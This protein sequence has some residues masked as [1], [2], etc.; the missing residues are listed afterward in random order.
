MKRLLWTVLGCIGLVA[1][2]VAEEDYAQYVNPFIGCAYNGHTFPGP[3]YPSGLVQPSPDSGKCD[4]QHCSGYVYG[5]KHIYGFTQ[6]HLSGTG[7]PDL[8]DVRLLPFTG[9]DPEALGV[10][11]KA[12]EAA[13]PGYY[14]ATLSNFGVQAE[15][16]CSRRVAMHRYTLQKN[17][18]FRLL[19]DLQWGNAGN[20]DTH[21]TEAESKVENAQTISGSNYS[22]AWLSRRYAFVVSFNRPFTSH[23]I[24]PKKNGEKADRYVLDFGL[25]PGEQLLVK[26]A[27][28]TADT[29]GAR[30]NLQSELPGW[31]F[32][33]TRQACRQAWNKLFTR[34]VMEGGTQAQ[35]ENFYTS[36]YHL[37]LTPVNLADVDGRYRG[38]DDQVRTAEKGVYYSHLSLWD[39]FRAAHPLYTILTPENADGFVRT[40]MAQYRAVGYLPVIAYAGKETFCMIGNH[41]VPVMVDAFSKGLTTV[42]GQEMFEA[43]D[44]SL[45]ASHPGKIKEDWEA[46]DKYG[47]YPFDLI[48]DESVS[49]TLEC[50]YNDWC[51]AWLAKKIGNSERA[52]FYEKRAQYYRNVFDPQTGFMRGKDTRGKWREPFNPFSL[53]PPYDYT[54]GN[55]W[56]YT[57]HVLQDPQG[58]IGLM[59]GKAKFAAKLNQLFVQPETVKDAGFIGDVTGLIG[60]YA[61]GNEPSHHVIYFF[62]YV[63]QPDRTA[64]LVRE[65][66]DKF[67]LNKVDGLCGNDDCG[68][69]SAWYL[70]SAMGFYPFNP[71]ADGYVLG[72]P[73]VPKV[74]M[75]VG[76]GKTFTVI[77][78]NLSKERKYVQSV[79]LNGKPLQGFKLTHDQIRNGG[80]L[81]FE[82]VAKDEYANPVIPVSCADP[83]VWDGGDGYHYLFSTGDIKKQT[84]WRS[85][86]LVHWQDTGKRPYSDA[87]A[88]KLCALKGSKGKFWAPEMVRVGDRWNLYFSLQA[89][90]LLVMSSKSPTSGFTFR[91]V[92]VNSENGGL[93]KDNIDACVRRDENGQLWMFFGSTRRLCRV[94]L[95]ADGLALAQGATIE[96][97]AGTT[98]LEDRSRARVFEGAYLHRRN[99]YWYLLVSAGGYWNNTYCLKVGRCRTLNGVFLDKEG[100]RMRDGFASDLLHGNDLFYGP[101]H[102]G[103]IITDRN[104]KTWIFFHSHWKEAEPKMRVAC[105]DELRWDKDGWPYFENGTVATHRTRPVL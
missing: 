25:K 36:L 91:K 102:N 48:S 45:S 41:S 88:E 50:G 26:V 34:C 16:T 2:V 53:K 40:M 35:R 57:W 85:R 72:A 7:C 44:K 9:D 18:P 10:N 51:A 86:D 15:L 73:Q 84:M 20:L 99:G 58:L 68:Q 24:L 83:T 4:W 70:F 5:D 82:M 105:L 3:S 17:A 62:L 93:E 8:A 19:V 42:S 60:Q 80:T 75:Q 103:N 94:K 92:L 49:R 74:T 29:E 1:I 23:R 61:H 97:V 56:Q 52:A 33:A 98:D 22:R 54:E 13:T 39:T 27:Y 12:K 63:D 55:A 43:I 59:G 65:V 101:G 21:I 104:G 46:Y 96:P 95:A 37:F 79:T 78:R 38:A 87:E 28:S 14:T 90:N 77:A 81:I 67:Y 32:E 71:C 30:R 6:T 66:F 100:R 76:D 69:M 47:Y 89:D 31:D 11:D 64:E